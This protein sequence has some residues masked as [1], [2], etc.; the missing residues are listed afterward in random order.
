MT[1]IPGWE[2]KEVDSDW[3]NYSDPNAEKQVIWGMAA[4]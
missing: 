2:M 1:K 4:K 3:I